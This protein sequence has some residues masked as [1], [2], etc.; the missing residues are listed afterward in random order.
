MVEVALALARALALAVALLALVVTSA[1]AEAPRL[2]EVASRTAGQ[3]S[4][5]RSHESRPSPSKS[6]SASI[7]PRGWH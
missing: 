6:P 7:A 1:V 4:S 5:S 3:F 2:G